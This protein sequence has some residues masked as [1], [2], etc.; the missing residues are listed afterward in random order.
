MNS[1]DDKENQPALYTL[2][3]NLFHKTKSH[4]CIIPLTKSQRHSE[5]MCHLSL[6]REITFLFREISFE[7]L[8]NEAEAREDYKSRHLATYNH[9]LQ[10]QSPPASLC[11]RPSTVA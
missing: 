6:L 10:L 4:T 9:V 7:G 5:P 3:T 1:L 8:Y 11:Q 2:P